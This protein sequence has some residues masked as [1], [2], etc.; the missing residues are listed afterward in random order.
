MIDTPISAVVLAAGKGSRMGSD[1]HKVLHEVA[2]KPMLGHVLDNLQRLDV[3]RTVVVVGA[4]REQIHAAYPHLETAVQHEQLG[5]AHAVKMARDALVGFDGHV[6]ILYGDV[7]LVRAATMRALCDAL[8]GDAALAVLGFRP[9]DTRSYGRL[10][11]D[12]D[13]RLLRIVEHADADAETRALGFCN[14][15][16]MAARSDVLFD[17]LD[18]VGNDNAKGEYYLTDIVAHARQAGWSVATAEADPAEVTGVNSQAELA[19]LNARL[20]ETGARP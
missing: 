20:A 17:L 4:A 10:V 6:L 3:A 16:I 9:D 15:G 5:T 1:L 12:A 7:P 11:T 8:R 13:G 14:S 18:L 2:G 19:D